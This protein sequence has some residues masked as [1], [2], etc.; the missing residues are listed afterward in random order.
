[1]H[2]Y[3]LESLSKKEFEVYRQQFSPYNTVASLYFWRLAREADG[4]SSIRTGN[5]E[6]SQNSELGSLKK[7]FVFLNT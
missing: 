2:L 1:M 6:N 5:N 7:N 4:K 3:G